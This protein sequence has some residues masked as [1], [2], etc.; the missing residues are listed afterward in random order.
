LQS[1][2]TEKRNFVTRSKTY[3]TMEPIMSA[4]LGSSMSAVPC[5]RIIDFE[6]AELRR[7]PFQDSL[8]LWV[9]GRLPANGF[10]ARLSPRIYQGRPDY[11][12]IEVAAFAQVNPANDTGDLGDKGEGDLMFERS[13]PLTGIT[14]TRGVTVIGAN[15]EQRIDIDGEAF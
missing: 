6:K 9:R 1:I 8:Y 15:Q 10:D 4:T 11:W 5:G 14:G 12:A 7:L 3:I 2:E 13:V